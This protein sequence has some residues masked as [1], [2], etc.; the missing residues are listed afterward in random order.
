ME[1]AGAATPREVVCDQVLA[2]GEPATLSHRTALSTS[3]RCNRADPFFHKADRASLSVGPPWDTLDGLAATS[4]DAPASLCRGSRRSAK[5]RPC[6]VRSRPQHHPALAES[7]PRV[8]AV[9]DAGMP[10]R[11]QGKPKWEGHDMTWQRQRP[12]SLTNG[13]RR[14]QPQQRQP[15]SLTKGGRFISRLWLTAGPICGSLLVGPSRGSLLE[16]AE[17]R[18]PVRPSESK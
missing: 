13:D 18:F 8:D 5:Q 17:Q 2:G 11:R 15:T 12:T 3:H 1:I 6:R 16:G 14:Q 10:R 4:R 9:A 7:W